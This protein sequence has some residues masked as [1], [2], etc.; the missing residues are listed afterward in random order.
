MGHWA[1]RKIGRPTPAVT[2]DLR[3]SSPQ[4]D[5]HRPHPFCPGWGSQGATGQGVG[6]PSARRQVSTGSRTVP[7]TPSKRK[8]TPTVAQSQGAAEPRWPRRPQS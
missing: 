3:V 2:A 5:Q 8:A 7:T 1:W 4:E 6:L